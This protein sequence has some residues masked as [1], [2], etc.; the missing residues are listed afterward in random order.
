MT[1]GLVW[2]A[3]ALFAV[4]GGVIAFAAARGNT[5]SAAD[6]YLGGRRIGGVVAGLSYAATTYSAFMLVVLTGLTYRGGVGAL[7]FELVYFSGL[8]LLV[9]FGPRFWLAAR[10]WDFITPAEM[11]AAR[12]GDRNV[13]RLV[14]VVSLVFLMPYCTTQMAGIGLL[15][16]GVTGGAI[17]LDAAVATGA[18]LAIFWTLVAGLRSVAWT[19]AGQAAVMLVSSLLALGFVVSAI[20]GVGDFVTALR[21]ERGEWLDVP[22]PGLWSFSTFLALAL[23]WFFFPLSNPQ[24]SQRLF[25]VRDL[26]AMRRMIVWVLGFGLVF[27][28]IAVVWG[29]AAL[30][31]VPGLENTATATPALLGSGAVPAAVGILLVIGILSAAVSTLDSIALTLGS[32]VARDLGRR[33]VRDARQVLLGRLTVVLVVLFAAIFAVREAAIVEQLAALSAAA[34]IVTVPATIGAFFW[35]RGTAAGT[36][37]SLIG[38]ALTAAWL[39][40]VRG[41]S[42]FDPTL[43][44]SV[45]GVSTALFAGVSLATRSRPEALDFPRELRTDLDRHRVW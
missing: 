25:V 6:Y 11:L 20:G 29:F 27:T 12:Y 42:V 44:L 9:V 17:G 39:A 40:M 14:A 24:V 26:A 5:G 36:L 3:V 22:G 37:A 1:P 41:V 32:M 8:T 4:I 38:G 21:T 10:R 45:L 34:L 31:L 28:L 30:I 13:G 35:R 43:P 2:A 18:I 16:S 33:D 15:L 19:D 7:G 23:P